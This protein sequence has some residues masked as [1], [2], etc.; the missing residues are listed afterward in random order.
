M[1][2]T[3]NPDNIR[4]IWFLRDGMKTW[5]GHVQRVFRDGSVEAWFHD[6]NGGVGYV[7]RCW[8]GTWVNTAPGKVEE[9]RTVIFYC[10]E[11]YTKDGKMV[12]T[13]SG[14]GR[15]KNTLDTTFNTK[16][17]AQRHAATCNKDDP[18]HVYKVAETV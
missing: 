4:T 1:N 11:K 6:G 5:L 16:R 3:E 17:T 15:N 9:K 18:K 2:Q 10:V 12:A 13:M 14:M 8:K 7:L